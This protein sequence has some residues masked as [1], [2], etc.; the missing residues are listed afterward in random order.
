MSAQI[1]SLQQPLIFSQSVETKVKHEFL[2]NSEQLQKLAESGDPA[3]QCMLGTSLRIGLLGL[4]INKEE[5]N[6]WMAKAKQ[7]TDSAAGI[8]AQGICYQYG[9]CDVVVKNLEKAKTFYAKA[10]EAGFI[11]A[12]YMYAWMLGDEEDKADESIRQGHS[13]QTVSAALANL[14]VSRQEIRQ[15]IVSMVA[16]CAEQGYASAQNYLAILYESGWGGCPKDIKEAVKF[17]TLAA[18]QGFATARRNLG[19]CYKMGTGVTKNSD[20]A[21]KW[22]TLAAEQG[23]EKAIVELK[24]ASCCC[25]VM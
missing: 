5:G 8:Y 9:I 4:K 16:Q 13:Y 3:G 6:K 2:L 1:Q 25:L 23:E 18:N 17:Y 22:F 12:I 14:A 10:G 21:I 24:N 7:H 20:E 15:K 19:L 11:P